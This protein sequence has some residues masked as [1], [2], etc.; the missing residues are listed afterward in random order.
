MYLVSPEFKSL[1]TPRSVRGFR[2]SGIRGAVTS[3][4]GAVSRSS[5]VPRSGGSHCVAVSAMHTTILQVRMEESPAASVRLA[6]IR[7]VS[8]ADAEQLLDGQ[9]LHPGEAVA[10]GA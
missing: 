7:V 2:R 8:S 6:V 10:L 3:T 5:E 9:P 1:R 4:S